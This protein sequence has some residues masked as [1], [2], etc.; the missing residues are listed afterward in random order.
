[1]TAGMGCAASRSTSAAETPV[2]TKAEPL[3]TTGHI[4]QSKA[5]AMLKDV[6][7]PPAVVRAA[8]PQ[9]SLAMVQNQVAGIVSASV[10][11]GRDGLVKDVVVLKDIGFDSAEMTRQALNQYRFEPARKAGTPVSVWI[12]LTVNFRSPKLKYQ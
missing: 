9:Y 6:D 2:V 11:V 8:A 12:T 1:M 5:D 4:D 7:T 3:P 10:L